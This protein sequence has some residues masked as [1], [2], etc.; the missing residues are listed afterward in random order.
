MWRKNESRSVRKSMRKPGCRKSDGVLNAVG[1]ELGISLPNER[2]FDTGLAFGSIG[3]VAPQL[4]VR[5][6][7]DQIAASP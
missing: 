5:K 2:S 1:K 6:L 3:A 7:V 4:Q